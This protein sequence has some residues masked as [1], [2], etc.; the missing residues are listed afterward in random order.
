[1][2]TFAENKAQQFAQP[3]QLPESEAQ[4]EE[5]LKANKHWWET[6]PMHY[7]WLDKIPY[8]DRRRV[9]RKGLALS[10]DACAG[11]FSTAILHELARGGLIELPPRP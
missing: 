9:L 7:D 2:S 1:M 10:L 4:R 3:T 6:N 8:P 5:W 11:P